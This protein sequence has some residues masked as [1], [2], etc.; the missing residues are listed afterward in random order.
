MPVH[1]INSIIIPSVKCL[2]IFKDS[3]ISV[4]N[5][6]TLEINRLYGMHLDVSIITLTVTHR[7]YALCMIL[8]PQLATTP[9][10][11]VYFIRTYEL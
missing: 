5:S 6:C 2:K 1:Q 3:T 10:F 7:L 4:K 11:S 8:P 9:A